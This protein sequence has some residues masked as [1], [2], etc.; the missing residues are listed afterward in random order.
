MKLGKWFDRRLPDRQ[1]ILGVYAVIVFLVYSWTLVISFYK[2][3]SWT[4]YLTVGQILS[5]YAYAFS[6]NLL[7]SILVL[8]GILFLDL[9]L[10]LALR[11]MEE[12]QSRSI[13]LFLVVASSSMFRLASFQ[14]YGAIEAFLSGEATWWLV[15]FS[16]GMAISV[17]ASKIK[18][19]RNFLEAI[20]ERTVVFLYIYIPLS[21]VSLVIVVVRNIY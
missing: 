2:F 5:V 8:A 10:F 9:T 15:V 6:V 3:P 7:E 4:F 19:V 13:F 14:D 20:A 21:L 12:F 16:L 17:A 1:K 11:N 18:W